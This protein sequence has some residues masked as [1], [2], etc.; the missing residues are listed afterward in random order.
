MSPK[1]PYIT[2]IFY[3]PKVKYRN[4]ATQYKKL[5]YDIR[6]RYI[7]FEIYIEKVTISL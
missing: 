1:I 4:K 2:E 7:V 5:S 6:V 3:M